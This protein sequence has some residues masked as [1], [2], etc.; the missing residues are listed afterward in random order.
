MQYDVLVSY[1]INITDSQKK[2][3]GRQF[4]WYKYST[5]Q[6]S[7]VQTHIESHKKNKDDNLE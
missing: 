1:N 4:I 3:K 5:V 6:Y 2:I 7:T